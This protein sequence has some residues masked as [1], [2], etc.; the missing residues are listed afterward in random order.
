MFFKQFLS[1]GIKNSVVHNEINMEDYTD[2][3]GDGGRFAFNVAVAQHHCYCY[4]KQN[5]I[6]HQELTGPIS[7]CMMQL[8]AVATQLFI[9]SFVLVAEPQF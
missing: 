6:I 1:L 5:H 4:Q 9:C 2:L 7:S 8:G 3:V